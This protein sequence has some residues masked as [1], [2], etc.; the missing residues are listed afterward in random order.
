LA[1]KEWE[2]F[3]SSQQQQL[4]FMELHLPRDSSRVLSVLLQARADVATDTTGCTSCVPMSMHKNNSIIW[5]R[6]HVAVRSEKKQFKPF[7]QRLIKNFASKV[8]PLADIGSGRDLA[9]RF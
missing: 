2:K 9:D 4:W 8:V 5:H 1:H 6:L 3:P 7:S